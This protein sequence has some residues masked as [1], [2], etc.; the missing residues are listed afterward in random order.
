MEPNNFGNSKN[1][2]LKTRSSG[3]Y[4]PFLLAYM[5][6]RVFQKKHQKSGFSHHQ[7]A[8]QSQNFFGFTQFKKN[9]KMLKIFTLFKIANF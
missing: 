2:N 5:D 3:L 4:R 1:Q 7:L 8:L 6:W 9:S